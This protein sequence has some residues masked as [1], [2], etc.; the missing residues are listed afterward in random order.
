MAINATHHVPAVSFETL[1]GVI[2]EPAFN[3]T[4]DR[5]TVVIVERNQF[6]Q[7]QRTSQRTYLVR[8]TFHHAA[9]AHEGVG[10][11][12]N[13]VV[14]WTV[15]LRRQRFFSDSHTHRVSDAL[16]QRT[17]SR[18][19]TRGITHFRVTRRFGV[20]LTEVLQ[21]RHRQVVAGEVQQT[22]NQH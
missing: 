3:V 4:I 20:Q 11:V 6:A 21:L 2:S 12:V 18:F 5:N 16:T 8:D 15:K 1:R 19:H 14:T 22:I 17:G 13:N 9:V 7:L 10:E